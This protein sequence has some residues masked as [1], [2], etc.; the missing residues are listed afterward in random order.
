VIFIQGNSI[1]KDNFLHSFPA[2]PVE[3]VNEIRAGKSPARFRQP[4]FFLHSVSLL[5][6]EITENSSVFTQG[7]SLHER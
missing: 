2:E 6:L 5:E 4:F 3:T 1:A 7:N